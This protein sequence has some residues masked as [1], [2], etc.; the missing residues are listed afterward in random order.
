MIGLYKTVLSIACMLVTT[1]AS[2]EAVDKA[3]APLNLPEDV[4]LFDAGVGMTRDEFV[5]VA[6]YWSPQMKAD[7]ANN[8]GDRFEL[9][10]LSMASKKLAEEARKWTPEND[11]SW[12]WKKEFAIRNLLRG[13][14]VDRFVE[15]L[16]VPDMTALAKERYTVDKE[17]MVLAPERRLSSHI[18]FMCRPGCDRD[19]QRKAAENVLKQLRAG[20]DFGELAEKY[21]EDPGSSK[22]KGLF[23][24]WLARDEP[25]VAGRYLLGVYGLNKPGEISDIIESRF[26]F[27]I[28]RLEGIQEEHIPTFAEVKENLVLQLENDYKKQMAL[29]F[30]RKYQFSDDG[31]IDGAA[32][33][34]IFAPYKT[35]QPKTQD[36]KAKTPLEKAQ[37]VEPKQ[38]VE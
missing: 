28:I 23:N 7:A 10:S 9:I 35:E 15:S 21:S 33:E 29:N 36:A 34:E 22:K 3:K 11:G 38:A 4:V 32:M 24:K 26:G 16:V 19:K 14:M 18:L 31:Y 30:D 27:H 2:A 20:A 5:E 12:Y 25:H 1:L 8:V 17:S 13:L 6:K 37:P